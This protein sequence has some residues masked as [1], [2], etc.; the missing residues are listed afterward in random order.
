MNLYDV[1]LE[2]IAWF[3]LKCVCVMTAKIVPMKN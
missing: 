3:L 1:P 2:R